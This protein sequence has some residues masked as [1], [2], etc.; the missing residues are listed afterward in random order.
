[1]EPTYLARK[2]DSGGPVYVLK[3]NYPQSLPPSLPHRNGMSLPSVSFIALHTAGVTVFLIKVTPF[4]ISPKCKHSRI[5]QGTLPYPR[6]R[7]RGEA[8]AAL[9]STCFC[10][11][12][13]FVPPASQVDF[14]PF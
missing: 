4:F 11:P 1:M 3:P 6:R 7:S 9:S 13:R 2:S 12:R 10:D 14:A 8:T 5:H